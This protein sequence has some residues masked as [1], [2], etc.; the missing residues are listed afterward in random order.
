M[1]RIIAGT[2]RGRRLT[3]PASGTRPTSD[4]VREAMF[5]SVE[6][7]LLASARTWD[8]VSVCDL[9][10]GSGAIALEAWSRGAQRVVAVDSARDAV[11]VMEANVAALGVRGVQ[12]LRADAGTLLSGPPPGGSFDVVIADP[13]YDDDASSVRRA[14]ADA[15]AAGWFA[16]GAIVVV[17]RRVRG[18]LPL[19]ESIAVMDERTYGDTV[20]WYGRVTDG[21]EE[22]PR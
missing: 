12:V 22:Q 15:V 3:I 14:L 7:R 6:S 4:R 2:A 8:E 5:A 13:P 10:A 17:E 18:E 11:Q 21:R 16:D 9:W 20:L 19:P 1:T